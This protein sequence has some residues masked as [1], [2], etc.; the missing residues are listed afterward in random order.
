VTTPELAET[1]GAEALKHLFATISELLLKKGRVD[2]NDFGTFE[3]HRR[4]PRYARNP[5]T[6]ERIAVAAQTTVK[7]KPATALK[8]AAAQRQD[9]PDGK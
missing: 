9:V 1:V 3:L 2:I 5:R 6:G 4:K 7:F 8:R